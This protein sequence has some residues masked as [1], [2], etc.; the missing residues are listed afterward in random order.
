MLPSLAHNPPAKGP[1]ALP[2]WRE[3]Q[4]WY[5]ALIVALCWVFLCMTFHIGLLDHSTSD[6]YTLIALAWRDGRMTVDGPAYTWLELAQYNGEYYVSFPSVPALVMLPLTLIFGENT[7]N[8]LVDGLYLWGAYFAAYLLARRWRGP[9]EALFLALFMTLG[10]SMLSLSLSGNVWYQAQLLSF[11][12]VTC[13]ALGMTSDSRAGWALGL[14]C[15]AFSV[16][17]RPF[18]AVWVPFALAALWR[19]LWFCCGGGRLRTLRAMLPYLI[20]PAAV[21]LALGWYNWVRFGNPLQFGHIYLPE[22]ATQPQFSLRYVASHVQELL[23]L[24]EFR[25]NRLEFPLHEG[26]A[27]WMADPMYVTAGVAIAVKAVRRRW[28]LTDTLLAAGMAVHLFL[29]LTHKSMGGWHF[30]TRYLCDLIPMLFL[31][32]LRG[33]DRLTSWEIVCGIFAVAFNLYGAVVFRM[34]D[35][36]I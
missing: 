13:C 33:R 35:M 27:F 1:G 9:W 19:R 21:A 17:C 29:L 4:L 2:R 16:G 26:F 18:Q 6:S 25:G 22:Y 10:C 23:R 11:L 5:G 12:L 7:P 32:Q 24:P 14:V 20:A 30:G 3:A 34:I 28:D 36:G 31:I 15:L 8:I